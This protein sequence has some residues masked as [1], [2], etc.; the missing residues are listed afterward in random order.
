MNLSAVILAA[1]RGKRMKS[2]QPK[3]LLDILGR[4]MLQY[5]IDAVK[6]LKPGKLVV[7][8]G[9]GAE[10]VKKRIHDS[11]ISFVHQKR[12]LGTGK[13]LSAARG[14]LG[15]GKRGSILVLNGDCPLITAE[16]LKKFLNNHRRHGNV[17][18]LLSFTDESLPGYGRILR[19]DKGAV[20]GI[21]EDRHATA[22]EKRVFREL[23]GGVYI[24]EPDALE[25]LDSIRKNSSSGEYYLTDIVSLV[26]KKGWKVNAYP[27]PPREIRGVNSR[28]ELHEA[29]ELMNG[30]NISRLMKKGVSFIKPDS[31]IVHSTVSIGRDTVVYPGAFLEG[32][33]KIGKNCVIYPGARMVG[34]VLGD[35][36][37][38]KDSSLIEESRIGSGSVIG[39]FAHLRPG[40]R[41]GRDSKIGNFVE[42]KKSRIGSGVRAS[43][44]SYLGDSVIGNEV[45]IGAGTITCNYDGKNKYETVIGPGVFVG[46]DS[47]LVAPVKI[48]KGAYIA[49]GSTITKD[50][51]DEALSMSRPKQKILRGWKKRKDATEKKKK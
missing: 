36:V 1:G 31:S 38:V 5:S 37:I 26:A 13:A 27:C 34:A 28:E 7:V 41:I 25:C 39:P 19:S 18:S 42:V 22:H 46:S 50:V 23:N 3:V 2:S 51:P 16:T 14:S 47:Q 6:P 48:G 49:A 10:E 45:N 15:R 20:T 24:I 30:R 29:T 40:N 8:I 4:P 17:L 33:T 35:G 11:R 9:N 44:L 21:T 12:L 32:F 43:H